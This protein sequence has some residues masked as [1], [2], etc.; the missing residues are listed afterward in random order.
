MTDTYRLQ[1]EIREGLD[2]LTLEQLRLVHNLIKTPKPKYLSLLPSLLITSDYLPVKPLLLS[3]DP[4]EGK[5]KLR[6]VIE[7]GEYFYQAF[8]LSATK[9][10]YSDYS[11]PNK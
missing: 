5:Y 1:K 3:Y 10:L 11:G 2:K 6:K 8:P 4:F 9:F 7:E